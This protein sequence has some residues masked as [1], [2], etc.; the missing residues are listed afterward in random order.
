M[1]ALILAG[2]LAVLADPALADEAV[3]QTR[4]DVRCFVAMSVMAR[5]ETYKQWGTFGVFYYTGRLQGR[6]PSIDLKE[7]IKR[8]VRS[9]APGE[10]NAEV[11]RCSDALGE[12][13]R[14][15]E[16]LKPQAPRGVGR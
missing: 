4:S 6:D 3:D 5:N 11:K 12:Q 13:S 1:K 16:D 14:A 10:Y 15:L 2:A 9:L 8:E 7:A